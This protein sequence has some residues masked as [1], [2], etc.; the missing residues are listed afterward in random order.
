MQWIIRGQPEFLEGLRRLCDQLGCLLI[1]DEVVTGFRLAYGGAQ[2]ALGIRPDLATFGKVIG[3]SG[4]L[5]VVAGR[6]EIIDLANPTR[7]SDANYAYFNGTLHGNP[8]AA[9]T[10]LAALD[11]LAQPGVYKRLN[12]TSESFCS[13]AQKILDRHSVPAIAAQVGSLWQF[14]FMAQPPRNQADMAAADT[15]AM[16]RLDTEMMKRGQYMLPGVRRFISC[17]HTDVELEETLQALD[18]SCRTLT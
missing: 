16:R 12:A 4:P 6:A 5:S 1:F 11:E 7:K 17:V 10:T 15:E 3:G 14:L 9:A 8:I 2:A 18:E 13:D